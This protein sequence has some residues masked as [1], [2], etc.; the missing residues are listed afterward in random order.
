MNKD[1]KKY[2]YLGL[3]IGLSLLI[4][5]SA[6]A[7]IKLRDIQN[8]YRIMTNL[9]IGNTKDDIQEIAKKKH[10]KEVSKDTITDIKLKFTPTNYNTPNCQIYKSGKYYIFLYFQKNRVYNRYITY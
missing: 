6:F 5:F 10:L 7:N 4:I 8:Q 3:S 2:F 9:N 1:A